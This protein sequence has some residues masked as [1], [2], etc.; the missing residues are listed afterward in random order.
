MYNVK[1]IIAWVSHMKQESAAQELKS[2]ADQQEANIGVL[3]ELRYLQDA[4]ARYEADGTIESDEW[5]ELQSLF[6]LNGL[7][8]P[9]GWTNNYNGDMTT[10]STEDNGVSEEDAAAARK[11]VESWSTAI[12][13]AIENK[14]DDQSMLDLRIQLA[15]DEYSKSVDEQANYQQRFHQ[16]AVEVVR[17]FGG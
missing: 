3:K 13:N 16:S 8:A 7:E 17:K 4:L 9:S 1:A 5:E 2:I 12:D 15:V 11:T 14:D 6:A 10:E